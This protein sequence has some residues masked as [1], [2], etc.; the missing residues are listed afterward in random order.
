MFT[1]SHVP[2]ARAASQESP[3][4][5][6]R[7]PPPT[8]GRAPLS[9]E[10][11]PTTTLNRQDRP[12]RVHHVPPVAVG[13][14]SSAPRFDR[15]FICAVCGERPWRATRGSCPPHQALCRLCGQVVMR[16]ALPRHLE[17]HHRPLSRRPRH[18]DPSLIL[19]VSEQY[20]PLFLQLL[21][22]EQELAQRGREQRRAEGQ[23]R[24]E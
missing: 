15:P 14:Q 20:R 10:E 19:L 4:F 2:A 5:C 22:E 16:S 17:D 18:H 12:R 24:K 1:R 8:S 21:R 11:P 6:G 3:C 9:P 13:R 23:D 7:C